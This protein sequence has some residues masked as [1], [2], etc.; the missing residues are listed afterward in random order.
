MKR[1]TAKTQ[2]PG[3]GLGLRRE[4]ISEVAEKLPADIDWFE[5]APENY[6]GRGGEPGSCFEKIAAHYPI[7]A[8]GL[9]LS[10]GSCDELNW[11]HLKN[12]KAFIH[13]YNI[14]WFSD[15]LCYS[16]FGGHEFHD[17]MPLPFTREAIHHVA[18]RAHVV[19]DFLEVPLALEN[20]SFYLFPEKPEMREVD[21]LNEVAE[22]AN[23][24]IL[25]DINNVY[26]NS[27][28]HGLNAAEYLQEI[29]K[30]RIR[31]IHIA[32]HKYQS[33]QLIIDTHGEPIC[34]DVW[35]LLKTLA[36]HMPLPPVLIERDNNV[37]DLAE[38][39][40]EVA[41]AKNIFDES[42]NRPPQ[43]DAV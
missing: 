29:N 3:V 35:Q 9:S 33:P 15:H 24:S 27:F 20:V 13:K 38:L 21:F 12:L 4:F 19:Q 25:L 7:V 6:M 5:V 43:G 31:Q 39:Q 22:H 41:A 40:Q 23:I 2:N 34:F 37:P 16:S 17:L 1:D 10:I 11:A 8:H 36:T 32:G 26:V 42:H 14:P 30:D 28:N 18:K